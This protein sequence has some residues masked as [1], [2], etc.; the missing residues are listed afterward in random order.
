MSNN[1]ALF[2]SENNWTTTIGESIPGGKI[3]LRGKNLLK[4]FK[5]NSWMQVLLYGI[6]GRMYSKRQ[7]ELFEGIWSICTSY[8]EPRVWNNR[9][10]ALAATARSTGSL[11]VS[12]GIAVSEATIYGQGPMVW[13]MSFLQRAMQKYS[14]GQTLNQIIED[15]LKKYKRIYGFGRPV[16]KGDE[17]IKPL[18]DLVISLGFE[19]GK[20]VQLLN[21]IRE[22]LS[23]EPWNLEMNVAA[24]DAA[25]CA[26][27][28]FSVREFYYFMSLSFSAGIIF[29]NIGGNINQEGT[30]YPL[31]CNLI[32]YS[33]KHEKNW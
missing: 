28:N 12:A 29:C 4:D 5:E 25:L 32:E 20:H 31:R 24:L 22:K 33:G 19:N 30:F 7:C 16:V 1:K 23:G 14:N 3:T 18:M 15:E 9:V 10:A 2:D 21:K 27:Q 13:V 26:D 6:T 11:G 8:P 17:R